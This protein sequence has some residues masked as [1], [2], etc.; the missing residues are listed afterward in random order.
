MQTGDPG[1][2]GRYQ[3][4]PAPCGRGDAT[5]NLLRVEFSSPLSKEIMKADARMSRVVCNRCKARGHF[6]RNCPKHI[7]QDQGPETFEADVVEAEAE[8]ARALRRGDACSGSSS[9]MTSSKG[10]SRAPRR[11]PPEGAKAARAQHRTHTGQPGFRAATRP[12]Q[13]SMIKMIKY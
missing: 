6:G 11:R 2:H 3:A 10:A 5:V 8:A 13:C 7:H 9:T 1:P 12:V 4:I